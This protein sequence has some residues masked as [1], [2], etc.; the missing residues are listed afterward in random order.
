MTISLSVLI[1]SL[2]ALSLGPALAIMLFRKDQ[3]QPGWLEK[4]FG[5]F[6]RGFEKL[7]SGYDSAVAWT[8]AHRWVIGLAFAGVLAGTYLLFAVVP[9]AFVPTE[10]DGRIFVTFELPRPL[11]PGAR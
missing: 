10:D 7:T 1:S 8:L 4:V 9:S 3:E 5:P 11:P 2:V 6:N